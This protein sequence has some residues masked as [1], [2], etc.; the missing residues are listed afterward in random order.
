MAIGA[1]RRDILQ[2]FLYQS[3]IIGLLRWSCSDVS[4]VPVEAGLSLTFLN[5]SIQN[6]GG[7]IATGSM[8][9]TYAPEWFIIASIVGILI[10]IAA[11]VLP[12]RKAAKMDPV[13]ALRYE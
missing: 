5:K 3:T 1:K 2:L 9:L 11:G 4:L 13:V 10:G 7:A 12:A 8:Q 6:L